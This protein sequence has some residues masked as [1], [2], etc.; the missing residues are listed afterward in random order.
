MVKYNVKVTN[1]AI[2]GGCYKNDRETSDYG[3]RC[4]KIPGN[5]PGPYHS[6][7]LSAAGTKRHHPLSSKRHSAC[8]GFCKLLSMFTDC[9]HR[10]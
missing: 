10:L 8:Q 7:T 3:E 6:G 2:S 4:R 1:G 5:A 9:S